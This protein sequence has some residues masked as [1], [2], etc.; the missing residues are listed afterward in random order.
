VPIPVPP[1]PY[2]ARAELAK[3]VVRQIPSAILTTCRIKPVF[4]ARLAQTIFFVF[5]VFLLAGEAHY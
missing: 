5:K 2:C 3:N 4:S 1:P